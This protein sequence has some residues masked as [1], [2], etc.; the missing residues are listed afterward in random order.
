M[1]KKKQ[2]KVFPVKLIFDPLLVLCHS[3]TLWG[4]QF[5]CSKILRLKARSYNGSGQG[6][7]NKNSLSL[8]PMYSHLKYVFDPRISQFHP[9]RILLGFLLL[10]HNYA[11]PFMSCHANV[12]CSLREDHDD[13]SGGSDDEIWASCCRGLEGSSTGCEESVK[14]QNERRRMD[15]VDAF[16]SVYVSY[17]ADIQKQCF[18][19]PKLSMLQEISLSISSSLVSGI[20]LSKEFQRNK[21]QHFQWFF[22]FSIINVF[23]LGFS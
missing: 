13:C 12:W 21:Q 19:F 15:E 9:M 11:V 18:P 3:M 22:F 17:R 6:K 4:S 5:F 20:F 14:D 7:T 2:A 10:V 1:N 8:S 23:F 16:F